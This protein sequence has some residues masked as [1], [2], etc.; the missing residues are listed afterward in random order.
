MI[1][2]LS[3]LFALL[4][5]FGAQM[6]FPLADPLAGI[7]V[8]TLIFKAGLSSG[9]ETVKELLDVRVEKDTWFRASSIASGVPGVLSCQQLRTRKM[10]PYVI[11]DVDVE[12][13]SAL[14]IL[15]GQKV[16]REVRVQVMKQLP[17]V[18]EVNVSLSSPNEKLTQR[19]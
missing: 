16:A 8:S 13:D 3:T 18:G 17:R 10:G 14:N 6:G 15:E 19:E 11:V 7:V 1:D 9:W 5:I 4:G 12:V 2:A